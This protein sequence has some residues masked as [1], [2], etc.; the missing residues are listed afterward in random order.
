MTLDMSLFTFC[1]DKLWKTIVYGSG[2]STENSG[3]FS[4]YF[5]LLLYII[6]V[7]PLLFLYLSTL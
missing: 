7:I 6:P 3:N 4:S 5:T 1:Y 2:K